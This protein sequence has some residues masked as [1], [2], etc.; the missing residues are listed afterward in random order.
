MNIEKSDK[1]WF[2]PDMIIKKID[3]STSEELQTFLNHFKD[4]FMLCEG[5]SPS[6]ID[7]LRACPTNKDIFQDKLCLGIYKDTV[8]IAFID[9]IKNYPTQDVLTIGYF[10]V[11]PSYHSLGLGTRIIHFL[12]QWTFDHGFTKLRLSVQSQNPKALAFWQKNDFN[13]V[14]KIKE[15]LGEKTNETYILEYVSQK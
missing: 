6:A 10:L 8:F 11:H 5:V 13:I 4:F 2:L 3:H 14:R 9:M 15:E 1:D 12:T 7:V